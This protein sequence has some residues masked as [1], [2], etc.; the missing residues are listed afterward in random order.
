[1]KV[2]LAYEGFFG[3]TD[4]ELYATLR[5]AKELGVIVTAHCENS[6]LIAAMQQTLLA[7]GK[8]GPEWHEPSR[9]DTVEEA[10]TAKFAT[11]LEMTGAKGYVVHLSCERALRAA[12]EAKMRGVDLSVEV[13]TPHLMLEDRKSTRL[14]S[15][16]VKIS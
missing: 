4:D 11:F 10:G 6:G 2:F 15:S 13:V 14:N 12:V 3:V 8:T 9:P 5:L 16:H 7:E 1:F